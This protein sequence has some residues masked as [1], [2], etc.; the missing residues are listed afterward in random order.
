[1]L[2]DTMPDDAKTV[3]DGVLQMLEKKAGQS[4]K[5]TNHQLR[6]VLR[7]ARSASIDDEAGILEMVGPEEWEL[8]V[9]LMRARFFYSYVKFLPPAMVRGVLDGVPVRNR[10][11]ILHVADDTVRG[12]VLATYQEGSK[13]KEMLANEMEQISKN[14][15]RKAEVEKNRLPTLDA[16]M[17]RV[18]GTLTERPE[19]YDEVILKQCEVEK[20]TPPNRLKGVGDEIGRAH[21]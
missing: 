5:R 1:M 4:V 20:L 18:R 19:L 7:L 12:Q 9:D 13:L 21:V 3:V 2:L 15:R 16:F 11:E 8:K 17:A 10:A 14:A 6:F